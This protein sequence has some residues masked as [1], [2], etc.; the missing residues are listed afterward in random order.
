MRAGK[1]DRS[2]VIQTVANG[3]A[4]DGTPIEEWTDFAAVRAQLVQAGTD[5]FLAGYGESDNTVVIFRIRWLDGVTTKHRV[6]YESSTLNIRE[7]KEIGRRRGL[8][9]RC[10]QVRS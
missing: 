10:E 7:I 3:V 6:L 5:E 9:L 8:E 1:L 4:L 2:I